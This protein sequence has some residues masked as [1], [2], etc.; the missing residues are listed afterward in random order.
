MSF[1]TKKKRKKALEEFYQYRDMKL[2]QSEDDQRLAAKIKANKEKKDA[3][4]DNRTSV[5]SRKGI[6]S[7]S[8]NKS[9]NQSS[10]NEKRSARFG[11]NW[12]AGTNPMDRRKLLNPY[13]AKNR[14][15]GEL[16][17]APSDD[18]FQFMMY[19]YSDI[20]INPDKYKSNDYDDE[21]D[22]LDGQRKEL[23]ALID[24]YT[25]RAGNWMQTLGPDDSQVKDM[26][27]TIKVLENQYR[28]ISNAINDLK[29]AKKNPTV[30]YQNGNKSDD[31][32]PEYYNNNPLADTQKSSGIDFTKQIVPFASMPGLD[33]KNDLNNQFAYPLDIGVPSNPLEANLLDSADKWNKKNSGT[34][35]KLTYYE[36]QWSDQEEYLRQIADDMEKGDNRKFNADW[37]LYHDNNDAL[38]FTKESIADRE[39]ERKFDELQFVKYRSNFDQYSAKG[40][41]IESQMYFD[42]IPDLV[43]EFT[44]EEKNIYDYYIGKNDKE[45]ADTYL[46]LMTEELKERAG[47]RKSLELLNDHGAAYRT[48]YSA[49][50][51]L[52]NSVTS[53]GQ[54]GKRL[55]L[56]DTDPIEK[57]ENQYAYEYMRPELGGFEGMVNDV[58]YTTA[59]MA[60]SIAASAIHP[61]LGLA[62]IGVQSGGNTYNEARLEG[63]SDR[64][65]LNYAMISG[66]SEALT[67]YVLNGMRFLGQSGISKLLGKSGSYQKLASK[68]NKVF[69]NLVKNPSVRNTLSQIGNYVKDMNSEG[70]EEYV[71]SILDPVFRN[72]TLGENNEFELMNE[73]AVYSYLLGALSAGVMNAP[74]ET[75]DAV[76]TYQTGKSVNQ[77]GLTQ[78]L[79]DSALQTDP[80]G[81]AWQLAQEISRRQQS[82]KETGNREIGQL[83]QMMQGEQIGYDAVKKNVQPSRKTQSNTISDQ[84]LDRQQT[85]QELVSLGVP[86]SRAAVPAQAVESLKTGDA[87]GIDVILRSPQ[88]KQILERD[89]GIPF[90]NTDTQGREA[91]LQIAKQYQA[92]SGQGV[93]DTGILPTASVQQSISPLSENAVQPETNRYSQSESPETPQRASAVWKDSQ[94][95]VTVT[96]VH[97][98]E[99]GELYVNV[100]TDEGRAIIKSSDLTYQN[101][102]MELVYQTAAQLDT[103]GAKAFLSGY[104]PGTDFELY[105]RGFIRAYD[106]GVSHLPFERINS[107]YVS[108]LAPET[109]MTAYYAGQN[110]SDASFT[111]QSRNDTIS[112]K[113]PGNVKTEKRIKKVANAT[114][115]YQSVNE[116][117]YS[118]R[119]AEIKMDF[120]RWGI[121]SDVFQ[122]EI[123]VTNSKGETRIYNAESSEYSAEAATLK[124]GSM[125]INNNIDPAMDHR[126]YSAH[127]LF[128]RLMKLKSKEARAFYDAVTDGN[129]NFMSKEFDDYA[130]AIY[131]DY[132]D[133]LNKVDENGNISQ[134]SYM[135][136]I[137][138]DLFKSEFSAFVSGA[139]YH[140]DSNT[141]R[142]YQGMF[143]DWNL[144][145]GSWLDMM[146]TVEGD[147][148][149]ARQEE[150][151]SRRNQNDSSLLRDRSGER[152]GP[153]TGRER[154]ASK[155]FENLARKTAGTAAEETGSRAKT[156]KT[157]LIQNDASRKLKGHQ[158]VY[159]NVLGKVFQT[160]IMVEETIAAGLG[161][162]YYDP[163]TGIIHIAKDAAD[164]A[165]DFVAKHEFT[166]RI[167]QKSLKLYQDYFDYVVSYLNQTDAETF[168]RLVQAQIDGYRQIGKRITRQQAMDEVVA[169]ASDAYLRDASAITELVKQNRNLGEQIRGMIIRMISRINQYLKNN[170]NINS[171]A[172]AML[173]KNAQVLK[174]AERLWT[175]A[176][177]DTVNNKNS[178][179][180]DSSTDS[181]VKYSLRKG[182]REEVKKALIDKNYRSDV[183]LTD[184]SPSIIF[185]QK[186]AKNL[187]M[188]MKASHIR[189]N[190]YTTDE[191][192]KKGLRTDSHIH[193]HGL[194]KELFLKVIDDLDDVKLAYRGTKNAD[195]S[196][197]RENF[198]LLVS[199]HKDNNGNI[200]NV[201]VFINEKGQC[202]RVFFDTNKIAT[203]F[204]RDSFFEYI[205]REI[206]KGNLVKIKNRSTFASERTADIADG[207]NKN[208]SSDTNVPQ[209]DTGVNSIISKN[210]GNDTQ[211]PLSVKGAAK[212]GSQA[213][214][215]VGM[216]ENERAEIL[217]KA[218]LTLAEYDGNNKELNGKNVLLLKSSYNSQASKILKTL[219]E[220]FEVFDQS[221]SNSQISLDFNYSRGS[222]NESVH[223]QGDLSTDFYDFA[224][225]LYVFDDVI[226]NAVPIEIHTDKYKG[227]KREN[228][229]LKYDY[230]LISAFKDGTYI[231]PVEFHIKEQ[232]EKTRQNN[233][234]YVSVTLG[235]IKI[236]DEIMVTV[237]DISDEIQNPGTNP[238]SVISIPDLIAKINPQ[239]GNFYKYIPSEMLTEEQK[240]SKDISVKDETYRLK[241]MR[242]EDVSDMLQEIANDS[243]YSRDDSWK[244]DHQA[245]NSKDE[246]AHNLSDIDLCYGGD[247]SIYS[248][249]AVYY[250]GE[251]RS[252]DQKAINV[253]RS[254][255]NNP[256]KMITVYRAVPTS[257]KDSRVRNGDWVAIV[258]EYAEEHGE[259]ILN[260]GFRIIENNVPAKFLYSNGDSINEFGYDNGNENEVYKNTENNVKR[261]EVTYDDGGKII[262]LSKRFDES[263]NDPRFSLK[264][265]SKLEKNP[266]AGKDLSQ[267]QS[268]YTYNFLIQLPDM[269]AVLLPQNVNGSAGRIVKRDIVDAGLQNASEIGRI[270]NEK[271]Y[272]RNSYLDQEL[273]I[274]SGSIRHGLDG[275]RILTNARL[276]TKIG[277]LVQN[278]VP[279]NALENKAAGAKGTYAM[280]S[281]AT[282]QMGR[283]FVAVITVEQRRRTVDELSFYDVTHSINGRQKRD[284]RM[285]QKSQGVNPN[286]AISTISIYNLLRLV[287]ET[288]QSILS[289]DVLNHLNEIRNPEG[290]YAGQV[291]FSLKNVS[292]LDYD[293]VVKENQKQKEMLSLLKDQFKVTKGIKWDRKSIQDTA[294]RILKQYD[295]EYSAADLSENLTRIYEYIANSPDVNA[296]EVHSVVTSMAKSVLERSNKLDDTMYQEYRGLRE[297]LRDTKIVLPDAYRSDINGGY[298][299]FRRANFRRI[300]LSREGTAVDVF[301][302]ELAESYP[303]FFA[304]DGIDNPADQLMR[305]ADVL[306][307]IKPVY[308]NPYG[309]NLDESAGVLANEIMETYF[310][311]PQAKPTYADKELQKRKKLKLEYQNKIREIKAEYRAKYDEKLKEVN[312]QN[313]LKVQK[314]REELKKASAEDKEQIK[315]L[316]A[317][318]ERLNRYNS[319][320]SYAKSVALAA[321]SGKGISASVAKSSAND[322]SVKEQLKNSSDLL[323]HMDEVASVKEFET[324][325]SKQ[326][327]AE[328]VLKRL[329]NTGYKVNRKG[330]GEIILDKKRIKK[331]LS[332]LKTNEERLAFAVV[333]QVLSKGIEIGSHIKH[334][335]RAYD[336]V[337]FAAPVSI[338]GQR[339]NLAV[340]VRQEERNYYKVH[341]LV[342]P[343]GSQFILDQKNKDIAETA[344][345]VQKDSGLSP[346]DNV[347]TNSITQT[348]EKIN[349]PDRGL[350]NPAY[351]E[352]V[353]QYGT[354]PKGETPV[355]DVDVP[356]QTADDTKV[357]R[358]ARTAME[359]NATPD[360]M[361]SEFEREIIEGTFNYNPIEDKVAQREADTIISHKGF[362][363]AL[364]QWRSVLNNKNA[365]SKNDIVLAEKLYMQAAKDGNYQLAM[366]LAAEIAE[367]GTR[368]GQT[369]QAMRLL[370]KMSGEGQLVY[371]ERMVDRLNQDMEKRREQGKAEYVEIPQQLKQ[372]LLQAKTPEELDAANQKI[373]EDLAK[374]LPV[375]FADKW[376][377]WRYLAM[378]GNPRTHIRNL[379]GNAVFM[380]A[381]KMKNLIAAG[382]EAGYQ[383]SGGEIERT[384]TISIGKE[385]KAFAEKDFEQMLDIISG[386]GKM[387]PEDII[388][389]HRKIF[390]FKLL[391]KLRKQ[392]SNLLEAEDR[393]FLRSYY[394]NALSGYLSANH[395]NLDSMESIA[396]LE[397]AR[398]YAVLEAQK[399]TYRDASAVANV[400]QRTAHTNKATELLVEGVLPFK[401]TPINILKRGVKYSPAGLIYALTVG[402]RNVKIGK[403]TASQYIDSVSSGLTGT[404]L[405]A[406]G[407]FLSSLGVLV[408]GGDDDEKKDRF[409]QNMG[410]QPYS[411]QIGD[412][413]YTIDWMAPSALPLFVGAEMFQTFTEERE[414]YSVSD[415]V[416]D[417]QK[418]AEPVMSLSMLSGLNDTLSSVSF[419]NNG[420]SD[421]GGNMITS[422]FGQ[423]VPTIFGQFA[424]TVDD[425]RRIS[426]TD[427][428]VKIPSDLQYFLQKNINKI[429]FASQLSQPYV[430]L[431]GREEAQGNILVRAIQNFISPGYISSTKDSHRE[432]EQEIT[433]LYES[434][435][436]RAVFPSTA[437][438]YFTVNKERKDLTAEEYTEF[439]KAKGQKAYHLLNEL[440]ASSGYKNLSDEEKSEC[441]ADVY[442]YAT[443]YG[444]T[445]ISDYSTNGWKAEAL[446][447]DKMGGS[448]VDIIL[449]RQKEKDS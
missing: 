341:R 291:K 205:Q 363:G 276:G 246:T 399:A 119:A 55:L 62:T 424:R 421:I 137:E 23:N 117:S 145:E 17:G 71:Q 343:D 58:V 418:I 143:Y 28:D 261:N 326:E 118:E 374:Q 383:K 395:V 332:Y 279:I 439:A 74:V 306:D 344:G 193:Y 87:S 85:E 34:K 234:L 156:G 173:S 195:N 19:G 6:V 89:T 197:R 313:I 36:D 271:I 280:I 100:E 436:D 281:Y 59:N 98:S 358:F 12:I 423:A 14:K 407:A 430:D 309:M 144:V 220:K 328:W 222:L 200:I 37:E 139:L 266:Y 240:A 297:Q 367:E 9:G 295:S 80:T 46:E 336:T 435:G 378:L 449:N 188:V 155:G 361:V 262:P 7:S 349:M 401:K 382:I 275:T 371:N 35:E 259:R 385:Y 120:D 208:A 248:P 304:F 398:N 129:I 83:Y 174:E 168:D 228:P 207:Y 232:L 217:K 384:K 244:M 158:R 132:H 440:F 70:V 161:N 182:A 366:E 327:T 150:R 51:S 416:E 300:N 60:P 329:E 296:D 171:D 31:I 437:S 337:T 186:D 127:E 170:R 11:A 16:P 8:G 194:G 113:M 4:S 352:A 345:G 57:S 277:E 38:A 294:N 397:R 165:Y 76:Q 432:V 93:N 282:D 176:L 39:K 66:S 64:D 370:K 362:D 428:N 287:N 325:N 63:Y 65:A 201:P 164:Q 350:N 185:S 386:G 154:G 167:Q 288:H 348:G 26:S 318:I 431:W 410:Y 21:I 212:L 97:K 381:V 179:Q 90:G 86:E 223:K 413:S 148:R 61:A 390:R 441:V 322:L 415:F 231:V 122:G 317:Q 267:D 10:D 338:N 446:K 213:T 79:I 241:V 368:A 278:A 438:K 290:Y 107:V 221:Y 25:F 130:T 308:V 324:F 340:V 124:D 379:T 227:T 245:P 249:K 284:S 40:K 403:I 75:A 272:V 109:A 50:T 157:G 236:E 42:D 380:P 319:N 115:S 153:D 125:L 96:G 67:Q 18:D 199:Q 342:M 312:R 45:S 230:V 359:A 111:K 316:K 53:L 101:P 169:D 99:N 302:Q 52:E 151:N 426:Y 408:I 177:L 251:G 146:E 5:S 265:V 162:G 152:T 255:K 73:D 334:K 405:F 411:L 136:F 335:G 404:A 56:N 211:K 114:Y 54:A 375:T 369:V 346:T 354:I 198:F 43:Y 238:S 209:K 229:L 78:D 210:E 203:V 141:V 321:S 373:Y 360:E 273:Q 159:L 392:N 92:Q 283:Q 108:S 330:F 32:M 442:E 307:T 138:T 242:G 243:G 112:K 3:R 357:R 274:T 72:I 355:R 44:D 289:E 417:I 68:L 394:I 433:R 347:F 414:D 269:S 445:Q 315:R 254:A 268:L 420:L 331:G 134:I 41:E 247:G 409:E 252:Y 286:E 181:E 102:E 163:E 166:H 91:A 447:A 263:N 391:E 396:I 320:V 425:T 258:K 204:G 257:I 172:A 82:G 365:A 69:K 24:E 323:N 13:S 225:M 298:E 187:P 183:K 311:I 178:V 126:E 81:E 106:S 147:I 192:K 388:R 180:Q 49:G 264:N 406:L 1:T 292:K 27:D 429:P 104:R 121:E 387:N 22:W 333:P 400:L 88:A 443:V 105:R 33:P 303:E 285:D 142:D 48:L 422:Y 226:K 190:V 444:K 256:E 356:Q 214:I 253:I 15:Q 239:Y 149:N 160:Q 293:N 215:T 402:T 301:Y 218:S 131:R 206:K 133:M 250:Y 123:A 233:R 364:R 219:A 372:E 202:N 103:N 216:A 184:S 116:E 235:K 260:N 20:M 299:A 353:G 434:V 191:A 448:V 377:A 389:D 29:S 196:S 237:P 427:K 95:P 305:I 189:E 30:Y 175:K 2:R 314:V 376:N 47:R 224:K 77:R 351:T 135:D 140:N 128:H 339:G 84:A 94:S 412:L 393:F 310:E 270:E 110:D 419:G